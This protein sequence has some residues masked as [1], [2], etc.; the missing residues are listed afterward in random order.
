MSFQ[1]GDFIYIVKE[2]LSVTLK[3]REK[4]KQQS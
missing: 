3:L 2:E 4:T 1:A